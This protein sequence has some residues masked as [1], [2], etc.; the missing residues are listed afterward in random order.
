[1]FG[2]VY[3]DLIA[4]FLGGDPT[5]ILGGSYPTLGAVKAR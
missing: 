1:V 3:G 4:N 2:S 5:A